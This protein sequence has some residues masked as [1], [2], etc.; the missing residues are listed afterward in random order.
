MAEKFTYS[1]INNQLMI[2]RLQDNNIDNEE[3]NFSIDLDKLFNY[4]EDKY[5]IRLIRGYWFFLKLSLLVEEHIN[6]SDKTNVDFHF[7]EIDPKKIIYKRTSTDK[8]LDTNSVL[9]NNKENYYND[10]K[11]GNIYQK[12][13][14]RNPLGYPYVPSLFSNMRREIKLKRIE[15][16]NPTINSEN[17]ENSTEHFY[18]YK[19]SF[20]DTY[21]N[22]INENDWIIIKEGRTEQN[23]HNIFL[24]K[25]THVNQ[26]DKIIELK[27]IEDQNQIFDYH[28]NNLLLEK[29]TYYKNINPC[30]YYFHMLGI[31]L[32]NIFFMGLG[33]KNNSELVHKVFDRIN[34][35]QYLTKINEEEVIIDF[36]P[37][38]D[39]NVKNNNINHPNSFKKSIK[40]EQLQ[41]FLSQIYLKLTFN[42]AKDSYYSSRDNDSE[43]I[44]L[45]KEDLRKLEVK[46]NDILD[47]ET[48]GK[49]KSYMSD[50]NLQKYS[51]KLT[52]TTKSFL[53]FDDLIL[54]SVRINGFSCNKNNQKI[55]NN[56]TNEI[57]DLKENN[58]KITNDLANK[59]NDLRENNN[60]L[61][62]SKN[63]IKKE[64]NIAIFVILLSLLFGLFYEQIYEQI[65]EKILAPQQKTESSI[66]IEI[67]GSPK[68]T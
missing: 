44:L 55:I 61:K 51:E 67:E 46:I 15:I 16:D 41:G 27:Y 2:G 6:I 50:E 4:S 39:S 33:K 18:Q 49:L 23:P 9:Y 5:H 60:K 48:P 37:L 40:F 28:S 24:F 63:K 20:F 34:I 29:C 26:K 54:D 52:Y 42:N 10:L 11:N 59:I 31:Y 68:Q 17:S 65:K 3:N 30:I 8:L 38:Q 47:I 58:Q 36:L 25:V 64:K 14:L 7:V 12:I 57:N 45:L 21:E 32:Y 13:M 22:I 43:R 56:L 19:Y 62:E 35:E 66:G 1:N 53:S